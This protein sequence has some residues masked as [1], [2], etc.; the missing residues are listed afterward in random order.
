MKMKKTTVPVLLLILCGMLSGCYREQGTATSQPAVTEPLPVIETEPS[1][2]MT[3]AHTEPLQTVPT[4]QAIHLPEYLSQSDFIPVSVYLPDILVELKYATQDNFTGSIIYDFEEAYLRL[5][6]AQKLEY[7]QQELESMG[8]GLKLWDGFRPVAAQKKLWQAFPDPT[9]VSHPET[10]NRAHCRGNAVDV[11]LVDGS[12][13]ALEM[14]TGFD[15]FSAKAD[16]DYSDCSQT[17]ADNA[18]ILENVMEK[19]GFTGAA[20][21]WWHFVDTVE[22]PVDEDFVP[23]AFG[24]WYPVCN[25][26]IN[27]REEPDVNAVSLLRIPKGEPFLVL[28][29]KGNFALAEYQ[30]VRGYVNRDYISQSA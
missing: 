23:V 13:L 4:E 2:E 20:S 27:L 11:T 6:T 14:P 21:E 18:R 16:R 1:I 15:D 29:W 3:E 10:G 17:A 26:Y 28:G 22:Y 19:H 7:V 5:G 9:Y 25:E 12:G 24:N 8:L 30:N